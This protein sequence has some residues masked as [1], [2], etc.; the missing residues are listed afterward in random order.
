MGAVL[1]WLTIQKQVMQKSPMGIE[2][3]CVLNRQFG[4]KHL[5]DIICDQA[6]QEKVKSSRTRES[7]AEQ[8]AR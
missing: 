4:G 1:T 2:H 8:G 5:L 7:L 3:C 6:L